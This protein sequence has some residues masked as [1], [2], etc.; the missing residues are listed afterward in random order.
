MQDNNL[1][2]P[3][4]EGFGVWNFDRRADGIWISLVPQT[5]TPVNCSKCDARCDQV[6]GTYWRTVREMPMFGEPVWLQ[7]RLRRVKCG[8]CGTC[9][10]RVSWLD[11]HARVTKRLADFAGLWCDKL[12]VAHV[13]K[14]TGLHWETVRRIERRAWQRN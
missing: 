9:A 13:C 6:H 2:L 14:L 12:P 8:Q 4:W 7:V 1:D 3:F 5:N 11:R 10:E